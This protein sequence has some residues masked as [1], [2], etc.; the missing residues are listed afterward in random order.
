MYF[1]YV[2]YSKG[3]D[4]IYVGFSSE[5][6]SRLISHNDKRNTGWSSRYQPWELLY[7]E[8]HPTKSEAMQREKQLKSFRG[9]EFIRELII[10]K[11]FPQ[12]Q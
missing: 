4:K 12:I 9:R 3:F 7:S 6:T 5:L 8:E 11:R 1:T 10:S 2:L